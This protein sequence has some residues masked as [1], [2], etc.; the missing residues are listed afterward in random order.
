MSPG[1]INV[2]LLLIHSLTR[3]PPVCDKCLSRV[4]Y[5]LLPTVQQASVSL[6]LVSEFTAAIA[7]AGLLVWLWGAVES[8]KTRAA[9]T[10]EHG[11]RHTAQAALLKSENQWAQKVNQ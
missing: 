9:L 10:R 4:H 8:R 1:A 2:R 5:S 6:L 7:M 3:A 11:L